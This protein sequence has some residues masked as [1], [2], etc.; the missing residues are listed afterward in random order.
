MWEGGDVFDAS[1]TN[2]IHAHSVVIAIV[3]VDH[4]ERGQINERQV[5][6]IIPHFVIKTREPQTKATSI[7]Q[8]PTNPLLPLVKGKRPPYNGQEF[9]TAVQ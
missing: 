3:C 9:V 1:F 4:V 5:S 2:F 8:T 6:F 7:E